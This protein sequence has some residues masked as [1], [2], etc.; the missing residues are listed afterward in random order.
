MWDTKCLV[1]CYLLKLLHEYPDPAGLTGFSWQILSG[2]NLNTCS[3]LSNT[4][5]SRFAR[6]IG[7]YSSLDNS[8]TMPTIDFKD[9]SSSSNFFICVRMLE[10]VVFLKSLTLLPLRR[11]SAILWILPALAA[12][13]SGTAGCTV[14]FTGL[15]MPGSCWKA[16]IKLVIWFYCCTDLWSIAERNA[17]TAAGSIFAN[18]F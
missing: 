18:L 7:I 9:L 3:T 2:S 10:S 11:F 8:S 14:T 4:E 15:P 17:C 5:N 12:F 16:P 6:N 1:E 13:A